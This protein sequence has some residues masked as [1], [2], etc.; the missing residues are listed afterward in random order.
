MDSVLEEI[1]NIARDIVSKS[2]KASFYEEN[3]HVLHKSINFFSKNHL[4]QKIKSDV[5]KTLED[6]FGHGYGHAKTVAI[7]AGV[8]FY[9][10][11]S[12]TNQ[13]LD[14]ESCFL[15]PQIA[16]IL[17]DICRKEKN[18]AVQGSIYAGNYLPNVTD[19]KELIDSVVYAI[20]KHEAFCENNSEPPSI[21]AKLL[22]HCLYDSD[23]FRWG[24]D[25]FSHML[26]A[27]LEYSDIT[28]SQFIGGYKRGMN[29][30][31]T[32]RSTFRSDTGKKYGPEFIDIG[33]EIGEEL[34][35]RI[36]NKF[37]LQ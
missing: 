3:D 15:I 21:E 27:M 28:P 35:R 10:E 32:I 14:D 24:P 22:S 19:D 9:L 23:K 36:K 26:W 29:S 8:I 16:G 18:H 5:F 7:E 1:K 12:R 30:L 25:N 6:N 2:R 17:H 11:R 20:S 4:I 33:L 31:V 34:Y 37:E 13:C